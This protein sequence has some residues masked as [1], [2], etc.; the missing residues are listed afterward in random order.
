[1]NGKNNGLKRKNHILS[2]ALCMVCIMRVFS[3]I[4]SGDETE[5]TQYVINDTVLPLE[6]EGYIPGDYRGA[7]MCWEFAR[8]IYY[9]VWQRF[10]YQ[11]PGSD[12][13]M[14]R[15][16]P[17]G[18]ERRISADNA[19]L[20]ITAAPIGSVIR[21]QSVSE[22]PDSTEG[23]RHSLILLD[24]TE[25]GCTVYHDW[26]GY[27]AIDT[28][29]WEEFEENFR[30]SIDFGYLK[31]IKYPGAK[32]LQYEYSSEDMSK[33]LVISSRLQG[34]RELVVRKRQAAVQN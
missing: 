32:V 10:F 27:A 29:T 16:Y 5:Q 1:M 17:G 7:G 26:S 20:F 33:E 9:A 25:S 30:T 22:G 19:R 2:A 28:F 34:T 24:K 6:E 8:H 15:E 14:L 4:V 12:D 21:L 11:N 13:D 3:M 23:N 18:E 31:Y